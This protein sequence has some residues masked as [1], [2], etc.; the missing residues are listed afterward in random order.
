MLTLMDKRDAP[1]H[2]RLERSERRVFA[3]STLE[4][5]L[6]LARTGDVAEVTGLPALVEDPVANADRVANSIRTELFYQ[7]RR[8]EVKVFRRR[9]R[10]FLERVEGDPAGAGR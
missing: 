8:R 7:G 9:D 2:R 1:S 10:L 5:F 4:E 6:G 3:E